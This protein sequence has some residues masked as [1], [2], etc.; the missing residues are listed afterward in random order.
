MGLKNPGDPKQQESMS[1]LLRDV[2]AQLA[3][4]FPSCG[5]ILI[6]IP[7]DRAPRVTH[8][9]AEADSAHRIMEYLVKEYQAGNVEHGPPGGA[10]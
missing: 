5:F 8:N 7:P 2:L 3:P 10:H 6:G 1:R 4:K 9:L